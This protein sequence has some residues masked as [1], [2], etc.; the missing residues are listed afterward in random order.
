MTS[1]SNVR[2]QLIKAEMKMMEF[3]SKL[4]ETGELLA[5]QL[6]KN[7]VFEYE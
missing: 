5:I 3:F 4:L 7:M 6:V 2:C 1:S